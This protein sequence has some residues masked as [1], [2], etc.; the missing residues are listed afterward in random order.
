MPVRKYRDVSEMPD[1]WHEPGDPSLFRAIRAV[2]SFADR[3]C[4]PRFPAGIYKHRSVD[5]LWRQ[6]EAWEEENFRVFKQRRNEE[7]GS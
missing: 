4:S 3:T 2:W 6:E 1:T 5:A 7:P